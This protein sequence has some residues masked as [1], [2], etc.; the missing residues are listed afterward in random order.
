VKDSNKSLFNFPASDYGPEY[1]TH[2]VEQ[3]K[4]YVQM[5]DR[6]GDRRQTANSFFLSMNTAL[7]AFLGISTGRR[8]EPL[9]WAFVVVVALIGLTLCY[10]WHR[11]IRS[12]RDLSRV[13]FELVHA[14]ESRLPAALYATEWRNVEEKGPGKRGSYLQF[15]SIESRFPWVFATLYMFL[16][17][18]TFLL[19]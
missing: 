12:Y 13:K 11:L 4:L 1:R 15:T 17:L 16:A 7:L 9:P 6:I 19:R 18:W 10:F 3:Y 14:L 2:L 8:P 5:T